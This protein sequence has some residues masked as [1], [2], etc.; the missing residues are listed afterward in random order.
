MYVRRLLSPHFTPISL[1]ASPEM[2]V[3]KIMWLHEHAPDV[4]ARTAHFMLLPDF[5]T[6]KATGHITRSHTCVT[7][8]FNYIDAW[9]TE[10]FSAVGLGCIVEDGCKR[11]GG[12]ECDESGWTIRRFITFPS[13]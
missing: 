2:D 7:C 12:G 3:P 9:P 10:L 1:Q 11:L 5:L 6:F 4:F 13:V 8:K